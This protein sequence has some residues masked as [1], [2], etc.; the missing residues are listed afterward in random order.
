MERVYKIYDKIPGKRFLNRI[1]WHIPTPYLSPKTF[2]KYYSLLG[3]SQWWSK[4]D[5]QAYQFKQLIVILE[6]AKNKVPYYKKLFKKHSIEPSKFKFLEDIKRIPFLTKEIIR[7]H[8]EELQSEDK[9]RLQP[10]VLSTGGSSGRSLKFISSLS[11]EWIRKAAKWRA[12]NWAGYNFGDK[13]LMFI[14]P[15]L[16]VSDARCSNDKNYIDKQINLNITQ[17]N[18][19]SLNFLMREIEEYK[20]K[21][22]ESYPS[23]LFIMSKFLEKNRVLLPS[24]QIVIT[25]SETLYRP[26]RKKIEC[27]LNSK[28]CDEYGQAEFTV[29]AA[30]CEKGSYHLSD[31]LHLVEIMK[32]SE[33]KALKGD[34]GEVGE[35][36]GTSLVNYV[37]PFIRY[38]TGDLAVRDEGYK[39]PCGRILPVIRQ[40]VG[41]ANDI[42]ITP[43]GTITFP[44]S[45]F[46][47]HL[48]K[49]VDDLQIIQENL[50]FLRVKVVINEAYNERTKL[51]LIN[52]LNEKLNH[53]FKI[54]VEPVEEIPRTLFDKHR[55]VVSKIFN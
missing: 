36:V 11:T 39:C 37:M 31:E 52:M 10:V 17:F 47:F 33:S 35:V 3:K 27:L 23:R 45:L 12:N 40:I 32:N 6:Y 43:R 2:R 44:H 41:R 30:Q 53:F 14:R 24:V 22:I 25:S 5:L 51:I 29:Y 34:V 42:I 7:E 54:S 16:G 55:L 13:A 46:E 38:K 21:V 49:G 26:Q 18:A 15:Y 48:L 28:I 9:N 50:D 19:E 20:P 4:Q 1:A 8:Y